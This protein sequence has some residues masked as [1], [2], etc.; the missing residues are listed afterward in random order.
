MDNYNILIDKYQIYEEI[1]NLPL[2]DTKL[3]N[4]FKIASLV[5]IN[6]SEKDTFIFSN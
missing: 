5:K 2:N 6:I 1:N 3:I 4:I